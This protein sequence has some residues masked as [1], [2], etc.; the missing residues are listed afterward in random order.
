[1]SL[2]QHISNNKKNSR[3][4]H[5]QC[6]HTSWRHYWSRTIIQVWHIIELLS[7]FPASAR[8]VCSYLRRPRPQ[9][10][11]SHSV[12]PSVRPWISGQL[13]HLKQPSTFKVHLGKVKKKNP[14]SC[15]TRA[16]SCLALTFGN[17]SHQTSL[18][19]ARRETQLLHT[20]TRKTYGRVQRKRRRRKDL[21]EFTCCVG[22]GPPTAWCTPSATCTP[23]ACHQTVCAPCRPAGGTERWSQNCL[24][25]EEQ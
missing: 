7:F 10:T 17:Q 16:A 14:R 24:P 25:Q 23:S 4:K 13:C 6:A 11:V 12:H 1:M 9:T 19:L 3:H 18:F 21:E 8:M 5:N 20:G 22:V 15:K 2:S